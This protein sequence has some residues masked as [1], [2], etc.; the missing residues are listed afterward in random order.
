MFVRIHFDAAS[1]FPAMVIMTSVALRINV[2]VALEDTIASCLN[3]LYIKMFKFSLE[4]NG[5]CTKL[6]KK[7]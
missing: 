7:E 6:D 3:G 5:K 4:K 1:L 2:Y